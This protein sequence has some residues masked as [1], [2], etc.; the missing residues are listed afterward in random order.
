MPVIFP[1][2]IAFAIGLACGKRR[3]QQRDY[4]N[5]RENFQEFF[6]C[7]F[8]LNKFQIKKPPKSK[9][10]LAVNFDFGR[11]ASYFCC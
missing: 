2:V 3:K 9:R 1:S 5:Y 7:K 4:K 6:H 11:S 8:L 10:F